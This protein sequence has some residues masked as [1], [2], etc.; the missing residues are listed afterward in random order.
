VGKRIVIPYRPR[1]FQRVIHEGMWAHR[2]GA[3]VTHRRFGKSVLAVN[4]LQRSA[5]SCRLSRPR[6]GYIAPT[7]TQGKANVWD[8]MKFYARPIPGVRVHESELRVDYP[9]GGQ[10]RIFGAD[11]PDSLRGLYFDGVVRRARNAP[12]EV[13]QR[14]DCA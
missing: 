9:N 13:V 7:Y 10:V 12:A 4:H 8:Y 11:N 5:V 2:F 14:S 3:A 6:Y 1:Q